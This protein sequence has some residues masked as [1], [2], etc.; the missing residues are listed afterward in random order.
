MSDINV[1]EEDRECPDSSK[2][3]R[4]SA[5]G[6]FR[7]KMG[8]DALNI[9]N[10]DLEDKTTATLAPDADSVPTDHGETEQANDWR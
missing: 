8:D 1:I 6:I 3:N 9:Q 10:P 4:K 2:V 7:F 5:D